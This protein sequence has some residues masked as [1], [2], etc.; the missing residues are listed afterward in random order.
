M[1]IIGHTVYNFLGPK[2]LFLVII[3]LEKCRSQESSAVHPIWRRS[4]V[5][6]ECGLRRRT[7]EYGREIFTLSN[8]RGYRFFLLGDGID[9]SRAL[10]TCTCRIRCRY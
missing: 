1:E 3:R 4:G 5:A 9:K 2:L 6:V 8:I 10:D 7:C